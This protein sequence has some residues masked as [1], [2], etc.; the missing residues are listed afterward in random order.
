MGDHPFTDAVLTALLEVD[1]MIP[2]FAEGMANE[3]ASISGIPK[4]EPHYEQLLQRLAEV[5]IIRRAV[6]F[7]WPF[8][9]SFDWEPKPLSDSAKNP[10][11]RVAGGPETL[12]IE[13]KAPSL[14]RHIRKRGSNPTQLSTRA[15][16][17]DSWSKLPEAE[18]GITLP[19]DNPVKDFLISAD[20]K[21]SPLKKDREITIGILVIIWDDFIYEPISALLSDASGL[22]TPN[23]FARSD[24]ASGPSFTSVDG[25]I[26]IRHL[27][28][29]INATRDEPFLDSCRGPFDYGQPDD[30]PPKAYV[31]N[32]SGK[33]LP[34]YVCDCFQA[35]V[36][37]PDL[38]AEYV[39][40]DL[41]WWNL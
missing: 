16:P 39:P 3:I 6:T 29:L 20:S 8:A 22:F 41:I 10:E 27:H 17:P 36:P 25:V 1:A 24:A 19:R 26:I 23:S 38:G 12:L 30:F 15:I 2:G 37:G 28:Q 33:G 14:F 11:L 7:S 4:H 35:H 40:S 32:P 13:V 9:P 5:H 18:R 21:F 31:A 34:S